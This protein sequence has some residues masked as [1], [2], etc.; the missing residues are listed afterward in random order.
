MRDKTYLVIILQYSASMYILA[1]FIVKSLQKDKKEKW[2]KEL[3]NTTS[4]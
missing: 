4:I 1:L 3:S 2:S